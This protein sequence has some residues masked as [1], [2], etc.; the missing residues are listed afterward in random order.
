MK[1]YYYFP[2]D[3]KLILR[4]DSEEKGILVILG[5][6]Q[7][8]N[9]ALVKEC[10]GEDYWFHV[11]NHPSGHAIYTGDNISNDA[12]ARVAALV[13]EQSKLKELKLVSVNYLKLKY[14]KPTKTPGQVFLTKSPNV[15]KV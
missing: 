1:Y 15:I 10:D 7:K 3:K 2:E 14:V 8:D 9:D 11:A 5:E 6:K 13:K 12:V 4:E